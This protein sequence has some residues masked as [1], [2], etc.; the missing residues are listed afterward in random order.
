MKRS[1]HITGDT[2]TGK[3]RHESSRQNQSRQRPGPGERGTGRKAG[4][5]RKAADELELEAEYI[6][7]IPIPAS[8][9]TEASSLA[10]RR[11]IE[12]LREER[13]L[14]EALDDYPFD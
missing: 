4:N 10:A 8:S 2:R 13:T 1:R 14:R 6:D 11:R 12:Q 9:A 5:G 7:D 3:K